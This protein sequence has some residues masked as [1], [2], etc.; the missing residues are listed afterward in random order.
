MKV[1][2]KMTGPDG[3]RECSCC[4]E[5][6]A[7]TE[8][9]KDNRASD[10][11]KHQCKA[12]HLEGVSSWQKRHPEECKEIHK[13]YTENNKEKCLARSRKYKHENWQKVYTNHREWVS[14]NHEHHNEMMR[15]L[16]KRWKQNHPEQIL[17]DGHKRRALRVNAEGFYTE[18]E[19]KALWIAQ[20]SMCAHEWCKA[21]LRNGCHR[22]HRIPLSRGGSN[23]IENIQL[24]CPLCNTR[25]SNKTAD[26]FARVIERE[27][28]HG[29]NLHQ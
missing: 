7:A 15:P 10:G 2:R 19:I 25:K 18:A 13:R 1:Y 17:A 8:F 4:K 21:D 6:K 27:V 9:Y 5:R 16:R 23:F 14:R 22:D 12:C 3:L 20:E 11:M 28:R 26:E 29:V 24:L